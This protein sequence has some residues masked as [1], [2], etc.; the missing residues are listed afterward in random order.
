RASPNRASPANLKRRLRLRPEPGSYALLRPA[1]V[2]RQLWAPLAGTPPER[3]LTR[4]QPCVAV[5]GDLSP[6]F[7]GV[8]GSKM[9]AEPGGEGEREIQSHDGGNS[10]A[11][12]VRDITNDVRSRGDRLQPLEGS[13]ESLGEPDFPGRSSCARPVDRDEDHW[14]RRHSRLFRVKPRSYLLPHD[15]RCCGLV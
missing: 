12:I 8:G 14:T 13:G 2:S 6:Q 5:R 9:T 1:E 7:N 4:R 3:P 10:P 15:L 11:S